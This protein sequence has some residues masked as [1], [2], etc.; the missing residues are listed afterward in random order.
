M[1]KEVRYI[2]ITTDSLIDAC[3]YAVA[4]AVDWCPP[5]WSIECTA[6]DTFGVTMRKISLQNNREV[7]KALRYDEVLSAVL[8]LLKR[9]RV[10]LPLRGRKRLAKH[11]A[12][13][14]LIVTHG[15]EGAEPEVTGNIV[16][17][18]GRDGTLAAGRVIQELG[19]A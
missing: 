15:V 10:P 13:L 14:A 8:L 2:I 9:K 18:F 7:S 16:S 1:L 4:D 19:S 17:Y 3:L 11:G 5:P 12:G 6:T